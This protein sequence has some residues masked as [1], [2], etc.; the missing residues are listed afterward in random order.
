MKLAGE[1]RTKIPGEAAP[2]N[3]IT[4]ILRISA[5]VDHAVVV[6]ISQFA[7]CR[8]VGT[9]VIRDGA[10]ANGGVAGGDIRNSNI[11]TVIL[12]VDGVVQ[13]S[14]T[15]VEN[16]FQLRL[17]SGQRNG[18]AAVIVDFVLTTRS[19]VVAFVVRQER[20]RTRSSA[21]GEHEASGAEAAASTR[22][23]AFFMVMFPFFTFPPRSSGR[24]FMFLL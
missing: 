3:N 7:V 13:Q 10:K 5:V 8:L 1:I 19:G 15:V 20:K 21:R 14:R 2:L 6:K 22:A 18:N 24:G 9:G 12:H 4:L 17:G 11:L 16:D 23:S